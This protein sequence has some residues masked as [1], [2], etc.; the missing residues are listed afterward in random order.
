MLI[1]DDEPY[2]LL[3]LT[4]IL[5]QAE[6]QVLTKH[7][8][9]QVLEQSGSRISDLIDRASNGQDALEIVQ[10]ACFNNGYSYGLIFMDC[11]MPIMDGY[12]S[13]RCIRKFYAEA[14]IQQPMIIA[15]TGHTEQEYIKKA[16]AHGMDEVVAKPV[17]TDVIADILEEMVKFQYVV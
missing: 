7:Y 1:V 5:A 11:N 17:P 14:K 2:N 16:F 10:N 6:K 13:A 3:A 8:G 12:D 4:T 15:C 9:S